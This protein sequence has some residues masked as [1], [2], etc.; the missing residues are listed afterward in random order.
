VL[1][2]EELVGTQKRWEVVG[3]IR[4]VGRSWEG[5]WGFDSSQADTVSGTGQLLIVLVSFCLPAWPSSAR[6]GLAWLGLAWMGSYSEGFG[7]RPCE[8]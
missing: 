4:V 1:A 8:M 5:A 7:I 3:E 2:D 6:L